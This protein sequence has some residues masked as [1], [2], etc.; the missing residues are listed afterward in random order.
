V[1]RP[2][3][4]EGALQRQGQHAG[5]AA[6]AAVQPQQQQQQ[7]QQLNSSTPKVLLDNGSV[8]GYVNAASQQ[9]GS[10]SSM[11]GAFSTYAQQLTAHAP[12]NSRV[13]RAGLSMQP[14]GTMSL[15]LEEFMYGRR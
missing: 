6:A 2:R 3:P 10:S 5:A 14:A 11:S 8:A 12:D 4:S 9:E 7:Q 1:H 13:A 15:D